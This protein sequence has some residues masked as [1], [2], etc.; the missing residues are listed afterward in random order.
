MQNPTSAGVS[1]RVLQRKKGQRTFTWDNPG[2]WKRDP[3]KKLSYVTMPMGE[4]ETGAAGLILVVKYDPGSFV[5]PHFH[6]S[7]YCSAVVQGSIEVTRQ[8]HGV[9]SMRI[10]NAGTSYGPLIAG[11]EGCTVIEFFATGIPDESLSAMNTYL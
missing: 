6:H 2:E 1:D 10:V 4:D 11:P 7:D 5:G 9:G 8:N 3:E